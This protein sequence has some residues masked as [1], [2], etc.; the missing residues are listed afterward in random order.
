[1]GGSPGCP[2]C[3]TPAETNGKNVIFVI[4]KGYDMDIIFTITAGAALAIALYKISLTLGE[5]V[6][7]AISQ[8]EESK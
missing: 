5:F 1:M 2:G 6:E 7:H 4:V 3:A 8:E